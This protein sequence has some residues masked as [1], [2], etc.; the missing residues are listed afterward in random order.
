MTKTPEQR[1]VNLFKFLGW[2]GG[3]IHQ[4]SDKTGVQVETLLY[5]DCSN[6][7]TLSHYAM[8]FKA[9]KFCTLSERLK[10]AQLHKGH[11]EFWIGVATSDGSVPIAMVHEVDT[12]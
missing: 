3:T 4:I 9:L 2:V 6:K 5:G 10:L 11:N 1:S 7:S 8:G 12:L